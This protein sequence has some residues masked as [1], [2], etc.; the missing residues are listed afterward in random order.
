MARNFGSGNKCLPEKI[1]SKEGRNLVNIKLTDGKIWRR[2]IDQQ[3]WNSC[4]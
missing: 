2:H 3:M 1:V 4:L